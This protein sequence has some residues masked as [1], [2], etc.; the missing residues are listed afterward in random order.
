MREKYTR[1]KTPSRTTR[2]RMDM[3]NQALFLRV[4]ENVNRLWRNLQ[5]SRNVV[6]LDERRR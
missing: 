4:Y 6:D 2:L 5:K 1:S 3:E